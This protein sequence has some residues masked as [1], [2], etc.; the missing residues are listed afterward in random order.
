MDRTIYDKKELKKLDASL[1]LPICGEYYGVNYI[2][3]KEFFFDE[4][5]TDTDLHLFYGPRSKSKRRNADTSPIPYHTYEEFAKKFFDNMESERK[6]ELFNKAY[7]WGA[8][9]LQWNY[10][11]LYKNK[12]PKIKA[13][14]ILSGYQTALIRD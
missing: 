3:G 1:L 5:D 2:E 4:E 7:K 14:F 10:K 12:I 13:V 9:K 8:V 11:S 6:K